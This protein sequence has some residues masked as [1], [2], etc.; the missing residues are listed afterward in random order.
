MSLTD[1]VIRLRVNGHS[2][3]VLQGFDRGSRQQEED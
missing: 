3:S 2:D 1:V